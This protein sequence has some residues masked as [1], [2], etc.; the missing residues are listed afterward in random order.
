MSFL[1]PLFLLGA[2]AVGLPILFHLIRRTTRERTLFSSLMFLLSSPPRLTQRSRLE[3]ILLLLLRCLVLCLL[4]LGFA[5]PFLK[6][7]M[8]TEPQSTTG[9]RLALLLDT[10]ASMRR[11][12]LW[13]AA[14]ERA[15][16]ILRNCSPADQVA[17]FSFD[18]QLNTI[19][20]FDDW[21]GSA[22][23]ERAA[24]LAARLQDIS[25]GWSGTHL[26]SA[27]IGAAEALSDSN[28]K[29][30]P[31]ARQIILI[32][33]LQEG[34]HLDQIQG[35]E[36]PKGITLTVEEVK[37]KSDGN[38]GIQLVA[39]SDETGAS[40]GT[41]V[42]VK[43]SNAPDSRRTQ[44][45][46]GWAQP[47][48]T[49]FLGTPT[50]VSVP[51]GQS[52]VI[53][54]NPESIKTLNLDALPTRI[55][56]Q[57]DDEEFDNL[58]FVTP[59]EVSRL[60]VVYLGSDSE[61]EQRQPLYF[62]KRAFQETRRQAV[63]VLS[64]PSGVQL[65]S[66]DA[67]NAALLVVTDTLPD[68]QAETLR[69]QLALGKTA[70][71]AMKDASIAATLGHLL[72]VPNLH[73]EEVRPKNYAMLAD[74]DFRHPLFSPF[75]DPRFSDFTKIHFWKYRRVDSGAISSARIVAKFDSGDPA[76]LEIP[77]GRGRLLLLT[78]GWHPEDSQLA[79]STKFVP[80]LYSTLEEAGVANPTPI[81]YHVGDMVPLS[82]SGNPSATPLTITPPEGTAVTM[83]AGETNFSKTLSPGIYTIG[84]TPA[85][86]FA[87]NMDESE[88]RT[89]PL[90]QDEL[91][92]LGAPVS[93]PKASASVE[94]NRKI[95]LQNDELE[96]R[97]KL[98]R[99]FIVATV[100]VLLIEIWFAGRTARRSLIQGEA[101]T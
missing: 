77:V 93:K 83:S 78:A 32:T 91:E 30:A 48:R 67:R 85:R 86:R 43:V 36:W 66:E 61:K 65:S 60:T 38:A 58:I 19:V 99:W 87:V 25:P 5:R 12:N 64:R 89:T 92:R 96:S 41:G 70:L 63:Q 3:H 28:V 15:Q 13:S 53:L 44:F 2:V 7:T 24:L 59:P 75:A 51:P 40:V 97:Q 90:P 68:S 37:S 69:E 71:C 88:S 26:G 100:G 62:L 34:S 98:W 20:S 76:L 80:F 17:V 39:D 42:R 52:R 49:A 27:L 46:V 31:G 14:R 23:G 35:Y 95:R 54:L 84:S 18:R 101:T 94:A 55:L 4:A 47:D 21:N 1:T 72:S 73:V 29:G 81:Q 50:D 56:L 6:R 45:K 11:A 9:K 82:S 74:I 33:D 22:A 16:S 10:S 79:L 8:N 57:G